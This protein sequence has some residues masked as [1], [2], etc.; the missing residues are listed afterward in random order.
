MKIN[1]K[2]ISTNISQVIPF[3]NGY[4]ILE[5]YYKFEGK[6]NLYFIEDDKIIWF[7]E[8]PKEGDVYTEFRLD[9]ELIIAWTWSC[10][11]IKLNSYGKI[12]SSE[13]TK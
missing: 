5:D 4:L 8:L 3:L 11:M 6:S 13:F 7:A 2:P 1:F 9:G 10:F 12:L